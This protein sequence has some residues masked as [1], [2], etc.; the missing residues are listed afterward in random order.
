MIIVCQKISDSLNYACYFTF[1]FLLPDIFGV[2]WLDT[3]P[4]INT[5]KTYNRLFPFFVT[6]GYLDLFIVLKYKSNVSFEIN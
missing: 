5:V 2:F 1:M 6:L 4:R 3:V